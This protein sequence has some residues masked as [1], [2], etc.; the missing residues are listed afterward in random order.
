MESDKKNTLV[1]STIGAFIGG[2]CCFSPLVLALVGL[3]TVSEAAG[4]ANIFYGTYKWAFRGAGVLFLLI[5]LIVYFRKKG[6]CTLDEAKRQRSRII[7][8]VLL[9]LVVAIVGYMLWLYVIVEYIGVWLG[10]WGGY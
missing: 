2:L 7:N 3:A 4:L 1:L 5:A 6:I 8:T 10:L 9:T